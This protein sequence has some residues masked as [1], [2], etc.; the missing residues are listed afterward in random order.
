M[1]ARP[2]WPDPAAAPC[3]CSASRPA[4]SVPPGSRA[5]APAR[6]ERRGRPARWWI[7][8]APARGLLVLP[9]AAFP[10]LADAGGGLVRTLARGGRPIAIARQ[11][12]TRF[13]AVVGL[14]THMACVLRFQR[15]ERHPGLPLPRLHLRAR[16]PRVDRAGDGAAAGAAHRLRRRVALDHDALTKERPR[17][18]A[19]AVIVAAPW[20]ES[21]SPATAPDPGKKEALDRLILDHVATLRAEGLVTDRT[22]ITMSAQDGTVVE[23][24]EWA[25]SDAIEKA[26]VNPAV[27]RMWEQYGG[28]L[29]LH[30]G[31]RRSPRR[32]RCFR[33]RAHRGRAPQPAQSQRQHR[34]HQGGQG[35]QGGQVGQVGQQEAAARG[36]TKKAKSR[37]R[38]KA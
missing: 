2:T 20:A 25:S 7:L 24:F 33:V 34:R 23:V 4:R 10:Q 18:A 11:E 30:P 3:G 22:P 17:A 27:L 1:P 16:R 26:H 28:G 37:S 13:V 29:R 36:T 9:V 5:P 38:A 19:R 21:S 15:P 31:R 35:D 32:G 6:A 14:C 12:A 8:P